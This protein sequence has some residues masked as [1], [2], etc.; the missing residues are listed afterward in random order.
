MGY[1]ILIVDDEENV[2][3]GLS[4]CL[5]SDGYEVFSARTAV[6]ALDVLKAHE[7]DVIVS[8]HRMCGLCGDGLLAI[9]YREFPSVIRIMLTGFATG[10]LEARAVF[11][12]KVYRFL[13]K[14]CN[15]LD[16]KL[17]VADSITQ[18]ALVIEGR[19]L[20]ELIRAQSKYIDKLE[21]MQS[22]GVFVLDGQEYD[23]DKICR[24]ASALLHKT[25]SH[26]G[27]TE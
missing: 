27:Q 10:D 1:K 18:R 3:N 25:E 15:E 4:R 2:I 13:T 11:R 9:V 26:L 12:G 8:D 22:N 21:G 19:R 6:E 5:H 16:L 20:V 14:P 17:A 7:I 24:E 23:A